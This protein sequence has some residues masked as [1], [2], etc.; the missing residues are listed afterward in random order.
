MSSTYSD[1]EQRTVA[2]CEK[3]ENGIWKMFEKSSCHILLTQRGSG[4]VYVGC[5]WAL[6]VILV[7]TIARA[8]SWWTAATRLKI[9]VDLFCPQPVELTCASSL[10]CVVCLQHEKDRMER[11]KKSHSS[12]IWP[13][14]VNRQASERGF[15]RLTSLHQFP[16]RNAIV[17]HRHNVVAVAAVEP[18]PKLRACN[19]KWKINALQSAFLFEAA[20]S[21][22]QEGWS[23]AKKKLWEKRVGDRKKGDRRVATLHRSTRRVDVSSS[24]CRSCLVHVFATFYM[25]I[26]GSFSL[27]FAANMT[28]STR[29]QSRRWIWW[30]WNLWKKW[31]KCQE[32]LSPWDQDKH[33]KLLPLRFNLSLFVA[34]ERFK[35]AE[36]QPKKMCA[37]CFSLYY[38]RIN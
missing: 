2:L 28:Q 17:R 18:W 12:N 16:I 20:N 21:S 1:G 23:M 7:T 27:R 9:I 36:S 13:S 35:V 24:R 15:E 6:Q 34:S 5:C 8:I 30:A 3:G 33:T 26:L 10:A 32:N 11:K 19:F 29:M 25:C 14:S 37:A 22:Q 31:R 4:C 38:E